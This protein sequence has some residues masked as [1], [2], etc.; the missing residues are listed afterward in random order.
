MCRG[1]SRSA[2]PLAAGPTPPPAPPSRVAARG[3]ADPEDR[4]ERWHRH[5][6]KRLMAAW[7]LPGTAQR[8]QKCR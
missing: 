2:A 4:P 3:A 7:A 5:V 1:V 6:S 8:T